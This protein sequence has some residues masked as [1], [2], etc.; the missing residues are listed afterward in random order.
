[1]R[2]S[3]TSWLS[4]LLVAGGCGPSTTSSTRTDAPAEGEVDPLKISYFRAYPEPK[5]QKLEP[6]YRAV[7][8]YGWKD[9]LG[10]SPR[11]VLMKAAPKK[12]FTGFLSDSEL[13]RYA[14]LLKDNGLE[15]LRSR[16]TDSF[17]PQELHTLALHKVETSYTRV[18]TL[19]T[20]KGSKS[21][22]YKDQQLN[23]DLIKTFVK[24]EAIIT[25]ITEY[26]MQVQ[27]VVPEKER[28]IPRDR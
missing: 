20:D 6:S 25:R 13:R 1:M 23:P 5:T 27:V 7:M 14:K 9:R 8:S 26:S 18:I 22:Y 28:V 24:C 11:D 21:Y 15:T 17:N 16:D 12:V 3:R 4:L 10:E 19:A 2:L